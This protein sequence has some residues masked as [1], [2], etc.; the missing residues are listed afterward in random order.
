MV[1]SHTVHLQ[2]SALLTPCTMCGTG[3]HSAT[4]VHWDASLTEAIQRARHGVPW[5][6]K[7]PSRTTQYVA[8]AYVDPLLWRGTYKWD[9]RSWVVL[10]RGRLWYYSRPHTVHYH[11]VH[12]P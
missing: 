9:I 6:P 11:T 1:H 2:L 12:L 3:V 8:Q 5:D 7:K 10:S 4:G